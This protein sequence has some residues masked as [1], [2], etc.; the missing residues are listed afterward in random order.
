MK[1]KILLSLTNETLKRIDRE[2][3]NQKLTRTDII[4]A[5]LDEYLLDKEYAR[6]YHDLRAAD[7]TT[8]GEDVLVREVL[9]AYGKP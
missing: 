5:A 7:K 1:T 4:R 8:S 6:A 2:A 3:K 9:A